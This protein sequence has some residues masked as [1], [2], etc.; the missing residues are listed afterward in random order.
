MREINSELQARLD[1]GATRIC[2]CWRV[3]RRDGTALGFTDHDA[4]VTFDGLTFRAGT[5]MNASALQ[6]ATG[7]S[8]DNAQATG[9]LSDAAIGEA[10]VLAGRYDG[11]RIRHWL[12]DWERPDLRVL[13]FA[14]TFGEI[15]RQDHAFEV[16]LRGLAE[17]LNSPVGR[18]ILRTC[19]RSLGDARCAFDAS[20]PGFTGEG[21]VL[22]GGTWGALLATG[23]EAFADGWFTHG[24][25]TWITGENAGER[26][27]VKLDRTVAAGRELWPWQAPG[28]AVAVGDRF[29]VVAGCDKTATTCRSKFGNFLNFRGFPHLPGDDWVTAYPTDGAINDGSSQQS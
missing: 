13:M 18:S 27:A 20:A 6:S 4:D 10:D 3:D 22:G 28:R 1:G 14:G 17:P 24:I 25:L 11:A 19:D 7:L 21:V 23:L 8:V 9:A 2:R 12:V 26:Q 15:K 29:R 5:G 16:E